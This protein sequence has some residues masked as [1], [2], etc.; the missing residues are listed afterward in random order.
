MSPR[1]KGKKAP[2]P[3]EE[4]AKSSGKCLKM[5]NNSITNLECLVDFAKTKFTNWESIAWIDLSQNELTSIGPELTEFV[6]LQI[7]YLHGNQISDPNQIDQLQPLKNLRKLT[8]HGNPMENVKGY[9]YLVLAKL[10]QLQSLD[11]SCITKADK[12]T[13]NTWE[14]MNSWGQK[15]KKK[16]D[17]DED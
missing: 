4:G 12:K 16:V 9:R 2:P 3:E 5:N 7:L 10:P 15:K 8:L 14:K 13:S 1:G 11:F 6:N 17:D